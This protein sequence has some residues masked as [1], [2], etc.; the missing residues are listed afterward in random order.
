MGLMLQKEASKLFDSLDADTKKNIVDWFDGGRSAVELFI[1][2]AIDG[3]ISALEHL[4]STA[5]R[6]GEDA[7]INDRD[8]ENFF[9]QEQ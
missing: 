8:A 4:I 9:A 5:Y 7:G 2:K 1:S 3:D 6:A